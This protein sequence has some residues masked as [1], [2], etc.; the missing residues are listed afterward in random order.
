MANVSG[1]GGADVLHGT[2]G[3]DTLDGG[4]GND[5]LYGGAGNDSLLGGLGDDYL[6]GEAGIDTLDGGVGDDSL[7]GGAGNDTLDGGTGNDT[8]YGGAGNDTL[9]GGDG[10]D[11]DLDG[12][13]GNDSISGGSGNDKLYGQA[14]IDTL[15]GGAGNDTLYGGAGNDTLDGEIGNDYLTKYLNSGDS[16][17]DG[18]AGDDTVLGG[19]GNDTIIGGDG[20]DSW[21]EGYAGNDSISGGT[22]NDELY[23]GAGNDTLDGGTGNDELY[24]SAGNDVYYIDSTF[25]IIGDS[26]GTDTAYVSASFVKIPSSIENVSYINGAQ[27]L[28]YWIDALLPDGA[29]GN[30]DTS[31]LG[32][33]KTFGYI[34]PSVLPSY[35]STEHAKGFTIFTTIQQ[36]RAVVALNY[37]STL[38]DINFSKVTNAAALNTFTFASNTQSGSA[39][40]AQYP[41]DYFAASDIFLNIAD[42]NTTLSD[43]TYGA[44]VLIHEIGHALGLEHPFSAAGSGG[45]LADAPFLTG[46]EDSTTWTV[47]SYTDSSAQY[48]LQYSPL[49]IAALQYQ[50][51]PSKT[52]RTGNDTYKITSSTTNFVWDGAGTDAIDASSVTQAATIYLTPGYQGYLGA[53][54]AAKITTAGQIT[55]N[56]GSVIENL[57]G[58][59]YDDNLYGN[60]VGNSIQGG[61][62]NDSIEGWDGNDTLIGDAG[63]DYLTGGSGNDSIEGGDGNDTLVVSGLFSNYVIKY[64]STTQS[65]SIEAK[66]GTDGKDTFKTIEYLKFSDKTVAMQGID[67]TPP[68]IAIASSLS[69]LSIGKTATLSF[70]LSESATDF[71]LADIVVSSGTLSNFT[72]SGTSYAATFTPSTNYTGTASVKVASGKFTDS[73]GNANEDGDDAN[74]TLSISIDTQAPSAT[75][76][77]PLDEAIKVSVASDIVIT[78]SEKIYKGAGTVSIKTN[79]GITVATYDIK[80]SSNLTITDT[81]LTIN[82]SA[83]LSFDTGYKVEI[84]AGAI[85][86]LVG[87]EFAAL[88]TYNFTT[89]SNQIPSGAVTVSGTPSQGQSLSVTNTLAD[90]DGL[91]TI[92]YQ[93]K[94]NGTAIAGA[95]T[96]SLVLT[97]DQVGKTIAVAASYTDGFGTAES[98]SSIATSAVANVNDPATGAVTVTGTATQGQTLTAANTLTDL[99]GLG[100][101]SYQWKATG[102]PISGATGTTF[103]LTQDQVGKTITVAASYTDGFGTPESV[104]S[105]ATGT[106]INIPGQTIAGTTGNNTL[107]STGGND[108]L[109]GGAGTDT[110]V[111]S[112][113]LANYT[114]T[115]TA[116]GYTVKDKTGA[117]GTDTLSNIEALKFADKTINLTI[118]AKAAAAPQ[119][120]VT[121]LIELYEAFFNRVPDANGLE[122]WIGQM[123]AG[124]SINQI[125]G[126]FYNAGIQY[127]S[128]TGFSAGMSNA[129]FVNVIYK[130]VLG[131]SEGADAGS[132]A[133]WSA[134]LASGRA[135]HGS[136]VSTILSSAHTFK[137]DATWGWVANLLGNKLTVAKTFAIDWGLNYNTAAESIAQGMAIA[138]AVTPT[139]TT[140]AIALIGVS[141]ADMQLG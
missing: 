32:S 42:Y 37:I 99:D 43:G 91:G 23:G 30:Y 36:A 130:N 39:G 112:T 117:D 136:L 92:V 141:A 71:V 53:S 54:K 7:Y 29:A 33:S 44:L 76:Y 102:S 121:R 113:G 51:G 138:A 57:I 28:P 31:L 124:Q 41:G 38:L 15:D 107:V 88:T 61:A 65:Y 52:A 90:A 1:T 27:A 8:L 69:S 22:G 80:T 55:V 133:Y 56:F 12:G 5:S 63:N 3:N 96:G 14:G 59:N 34:F 129:D 84:T 98:V 93:W 85:K 46:T 139:D 128:L 66:S 132:L 60:D 70:V 106:V 116:N 123:G 2:S 103:T 137:G 125:A 24:G 83:N 81:T 35:H 110:A 9:I 87:N 25:D 134:E 78:F 45:E 18:G 127:S 126:S 108:T 62:G 13:D 131:R 6:D 67:L 104:T 19:T 115:K 119:A 97:Q 72:G 40:Y 95:T 89:V 4:A 140:A 68:T 75:L 94:A 17:L 135:T 101:I 16:L 82:P 118:Q 100:T 114:I 122:Y 86:D 11:S 48:Y 74:N 64:D 120:D 50:Y 49:D 47:M 77:S 58:S 111:Y 79:A 21:L 20:N 105:I 10:D 109:D 73:S 26:G